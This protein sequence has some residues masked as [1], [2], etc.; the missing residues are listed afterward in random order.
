V[1]EAVDFWNQQLEELGTPFRLG[2]VTHVTELVPGDY[3]KT[4]SAAVLEGKSK[5]EPPE[6]V[7]NIPG[8]IIV[9]LS[10]MSF[11]SFAS[12]PGSEYCIIGIRNFEV[13]PL[14]LTNVGR[15]LI[16][17]ELGH[18]I[19]L[20][21][22]NDPTK[23]MCGRPADCRPDDFHCDREQFFPIDEDNKSYLLEL[24]PSTWEPNQ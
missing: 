22:H 24:Y 21:H 10:D 19:G 9:A 2:A 12:I 16:A 20:G 13:S 8:D 18:A 4:T 11:I 23:L 1:H 15:N 17:H 6:S 7:K 5:P 14:D 3:L